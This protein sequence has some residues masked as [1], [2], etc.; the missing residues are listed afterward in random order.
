M[1]GTPIPKHGSTDQ[2]DQRLFG[3]INGIEAS[4]ESQLRQEYNGPVVEDIPLSKNCVYSITGELIC[5]K[6]G[7][8]QK[9]TQKPGLQTMYPMFLKDQRNTAAPTASHRP[10][11]GF[12]AMTQSASPSH[13]PTASHRPP[14]GFP[15]MTKSAS[16]SHGP[17]ATSHGMQ[18][19]MHM[20]IAQKGASPNMQELSIEGFDQPKFINQDAKTSFWKERSSRGFPLPSTEHEISVREKHGWVQHLQHGYQKNCHYNVFGDLQCLNEKESFDG[21]RI[22]LP[23]Q[24]QSSLTNDSCNSSCTNGSV[25]KNGS[26]E[27]VD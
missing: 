12:P 26:C 25:C 24:K 14:M 17:T 7:A 16:P 18:K 6:P 9:S 22:V 23:G 1:K 10:P 8:Q 2:W 20:E 3:R 13:G 5:P 19:Q 15:E 4:S 27:T 11:M 21:G